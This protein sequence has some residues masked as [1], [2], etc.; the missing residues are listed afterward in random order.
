MYVYSQ[1]IKTNLET[2]YIDGNDG[3]NLRCFDVRNAPHNRLPQ[4]LLLPHLLHNLVCFF[5]RGME[6][7]SVLLIKHSFTLFLHFIIASCITEQYA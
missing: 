5:L 7:F 1:Y 6:L 4:L 3:L 2:A